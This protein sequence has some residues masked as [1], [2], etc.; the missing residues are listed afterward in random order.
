MNGNPVQEIESSPQ[1]NTTDGRAIVKLNKKKWAEIQLQLTQL[2]PDEQVDVALGVLRK[3]LNFNPDVRSYTAEE[4]KKRY[5]STKKLAE[6]QGVSVYE[7][8][9]KKF[10]ENNRDVCIGRIN[11]CRKARRA[12]EKAS[13]VSAV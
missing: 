4:S 3:V 12:R 11:N 10:Y 8:S 7:I 2:L 5:E 1:N 13:V 9:Q 6:S